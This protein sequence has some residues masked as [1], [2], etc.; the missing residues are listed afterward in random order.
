MWTARAYDRHTLPALADITN[1]EAIIERIDLAASTATPVL[2]FFGR[3][4]DGEEANLDLIDEHLRHMVNAAIAGLLED[5]DGL[6]DDEAEGYVEDAIFMV[7]AIP[8]PAP[9]GQRRVCVEIAL[10]LT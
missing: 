5:G 9:S 1:A 7:I 3:L 6:L 10:R 2:R 8:Q 4:V